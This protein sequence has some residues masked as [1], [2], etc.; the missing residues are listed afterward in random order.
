MPVEEY[1]NLTVNQN[2]GSDLHEYRVPRK[3]YPYKAPSKICP[4][5]VRKTFINQA[6]KHQGPGPGMYHNPGSWTMPIV[7]FSKMNRT[8]II[9]EDAKKA[10]RNPGPGK[11]LS[12]KS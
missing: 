5:A 3:F 1:L 4:K 9:S 8:T 2:S 11:Y 7:G 6:E 10:R 12:I